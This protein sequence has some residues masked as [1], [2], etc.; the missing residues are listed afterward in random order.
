MAILTLMLHTKGF[1]F[2]G[3]S[4]VSR[5]KVGLLWIFKTKSDGNQLT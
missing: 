5:I 1:A 4:V 3:L 2:C